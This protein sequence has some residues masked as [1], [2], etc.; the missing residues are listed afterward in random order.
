M[1]NLI[2]IFLTALS[3]NL[4]GQSNNQDESDKKHDLKINFLMLYIGAPAL[5]YDYIL[6][7]E[8]SVGFS[9]SVSIDDDLETQYM[10]S[11]N[12]RV[13]FGNENANG[14]FI[15]GFMSL[16][17]EK[18]DDY[19]DDLKMNDKEYTA[20][21]LGAGIGGKFLTKSKKYVG[22]LFGGLGRNFLN[23]DHIDDV[24]GRISLSLGRRF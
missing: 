17:G 6:G 3:F 5:N 8:T 24:Y 19:S 9:A 20:L 13:Y 15:E 18:K 14:F 21:G 23:T 22:E 4:Y 1:K 16:Y 10:I 11:P 12:F 7:H 2:L